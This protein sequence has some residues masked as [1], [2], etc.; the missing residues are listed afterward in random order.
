MSWLLYELFNEHAS[1]TKGS[2]S[3]RRAS[4]VSFFNFVHLSH[5]SHSSSTTTH[6]CFHH[7]WESKLLAPF[8]CLFNVIETALGTRDDR[9][10]TFLGN[11]SSSSLVSHHSDSFWI[12]SNE[13]DS[14]ILAFLGEISVLTKESIT[15]MDSIDIIFLSTSDNL[16]NCQVCLNW[17]AV[18]RSDFISFIS[19]VSVEGKLLLF[20][21][22][23]NRCDSVFF[24][25]S[26]H[27]N[28]NFTSVAAH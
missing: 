6:G 3:F 12:W 7:D 2:K 21:V 4:F 13:N 27:S 25:G 16:I 15:W 10:T 17:G 23:T 28:S 1:I 24:T 18:R 8:Y 20:T 11:A 26:E 9:N 14:I 19:F 22:N 5:D